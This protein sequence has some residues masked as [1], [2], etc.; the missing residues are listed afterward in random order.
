M[1]R[2]MTACDMDRVMQIWFAGNKE[3]HDFIAQE[4]WE[5]NAAFVRE[6]LL[7][8]EVYVYEMRGVVQGFV[9]MQNDYLAGIFVDRHVRSMGIGKQLLDYMKK[10]HSSFS[11]HVYQENDRAV[12]FYQR[13]GLTVSDE[14]VE[15]NTG[16]V[17]YTMVWTAKEEKSQNKKNC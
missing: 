10:I 9:G 12:A 7:Q 4:Y 6:Q 2:K 8:A 1:I 3:A 5:S 15:A 14:A 16:K 11:L 13:E 17:A